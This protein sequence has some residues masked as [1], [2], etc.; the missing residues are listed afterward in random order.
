[1]I[2]T[3]RPR[4]PRLSGVTDVLY[5]LDGPARDRVAALRAQGRFFWLDVSLS[6][7]TPDD[8]RDALTLPEAALQLSRA[9][10]DAY[11][12]RTAADREAVR[13]AFRCYADP[14]MTGHRLRPITV[15]VVVTG[16]YLLTL[17]EEPIS[18]PSLLPLELAQE[19]SKGYVVYSVLDMMLSS[20]FSALEDVEL[21]LDALAA[22]STE[23]H[24]GL[25]RAALRD[26][27]VTLTT[28]RRLL[29][30][31]QGALE[32]AGVEI[33]ALPGFETDDET[34]F[35]RLGKQVDRQLASI[36][37]AANALGM[38]LDLQLNERAYVVSV[39]ATIFVPLTLV[40]GYFGMNFGWL[41][42]RIDSPIAF[43]LLGITLPIATGVLSWRLLVR[44]F[45]LG[46]GGEPRRR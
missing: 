23:G 34:Y 27:V 44:P 45:V 41:V 11:T 16:E 39:L 15:Q 37:A 36:D 12:T 46:D 19:H 3:I 26:T 5:G 17:H 6:E 1:M 25:P 33:A 35:N 43:W 30:A 9:P 22:S 4:R 2:H 28:M 38:L 21:R 32:R 14:E 8:L 40:T 10:S 42:D 31:E 24:G 13:F 7:T 18:L 20:T 29:T